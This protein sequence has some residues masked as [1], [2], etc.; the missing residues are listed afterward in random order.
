MLV[1]SGAV[2]PGSG[3]VGRAGPV[4]GRRQPQ[5]RR[6]P[7]QPGRDKPARWRAL[8]VQADG[9]RSV[10]DSTIRVDVGLL[11]K[12]MNLVGELVLAR[13]QILQYAADAAPTPTFVGR[14]SG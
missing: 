9:R 7:R 14:R 12:L 2:G 5:A 4:S 10:A 1:E 3:A 11:D 6:D 8:E 13:N